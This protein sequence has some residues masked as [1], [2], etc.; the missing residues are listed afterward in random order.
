MF[1]STR[2]A[3]LG[4]VTY[5]LRNNFWGTTS[6]TDIQSWI[7][8]SSDDPNIHATVLYSPFAGQ[9][10]PIESTKWG[11]LKALWR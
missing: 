9:S 3:A 5:D 6:E 4:A 10:V 2:L 1:N 8:D 7:I 11:N